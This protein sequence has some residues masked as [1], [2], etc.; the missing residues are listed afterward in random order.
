MDAR[1]RSSDSCSSRSRSGYVVRPAL[2]RELPRDLPLWF[3]PVLLL[4]YALPWA[5]WFLTT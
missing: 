3:L 2:R 4:A 5:L 1:P